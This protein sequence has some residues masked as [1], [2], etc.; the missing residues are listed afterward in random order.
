[1]INLSSSLPL[2][3][4]G[5]IWVI[6]S[7]SA[8]R[9]LKC[10]HQSK[11]SP[12][13]QFVQRSQIINCFAVC[14]TGTVRTKMSNNCVAVYYKCMWIIHFANICFARKWHRTDF[15]INMH[16]LSYQTFKSSIMWRNVITK[17]LK[18]MIIVK[19]NRENQESNT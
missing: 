18:C 1:M 12:Q 6:C 4:W 16:V 10:G 19:F 17:N 15:K 14:H 8:S 5:F 11:Q 13:A 9:L 7:F 2:V 3:V